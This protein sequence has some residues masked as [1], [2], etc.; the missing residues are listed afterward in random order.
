MREV[1]EPVTGEGAA[2]DDTAGS[3]AAAPPTRRD[4]IEQF[5]TRVH[6]ALQ[7]ASQT[8]HKPPACRWEE[9]AAT[10]IEKSEEDLHTARPQVRRS[11]RHFSSP[12]CGLPHSTCTRAANLQRI[13]AGSDGLTVTSLNM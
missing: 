11:L 4:G 12:L 7:M 5:Q 8:A 3:R 9:P 10:V 13:R 6:A 1:P 2:D